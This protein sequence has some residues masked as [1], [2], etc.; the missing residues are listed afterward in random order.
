M[1]GIKPNIYINM[2]IST[3]H[4]R[5]E[6]TRWVVTYELSYIPLFVDMTLLKPLN[7]LKTWLNEINIKLG[8]MSSW[9]HIL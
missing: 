8:V 6:K 4:F 3:N 5:D 2:Q 1:T 7:Q 9:L